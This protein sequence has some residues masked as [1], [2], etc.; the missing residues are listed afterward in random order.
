[1]CTLAVHSCVCVFH[2]HLLGTHGERLLSTA[3]SAPQQLPAS[4]AWLR[5]VGVLT[6]LHVPAPPAQSQVQEPGTACG[7]LAAGSRQRSPGRVKLPASTSVNAFRDTEMLSVVLP[8]LSLSPR[9]SQI[10]TWYPR[11]ARHCSRDQGYSN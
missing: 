2:K 8:T 10:L 7:P 9:L 6:A 1:M 11:P 3:R 5:C 4:W